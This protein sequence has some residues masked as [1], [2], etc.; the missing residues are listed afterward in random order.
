MCCVFWRLNR[1][2]LNWLWSS[3]IYKGGW[4]Y[5]SRKQVQNIISKFPTSLEELGSSLDS[6]WFGL[7]KSEVLTGGRSSDF[8]A[9]PAPPGE[10]QKFWRGS[11]VLIFEQSQHFLAKIR[12]SDLLSKLLI[13]AQTKNLRA[14]IRGSDRGQKFWLGEIFLREQLL[15]PDS[16]LDVLYMF[17]C[18]SRWD[19][20]KG[21]V[22]SIFWQL[23]KMDN[24]G[25]NTK[26]EST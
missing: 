26:E 4:S 1:W 20:R 7:R 2:G 17:Y 6:P 3:R 13:F 5:P 21:E 8:R 24:F 9:K 16:E 19:E 11:E 10:H 22:R 12:T 14:K 25:F 23:H 18:P 15:H